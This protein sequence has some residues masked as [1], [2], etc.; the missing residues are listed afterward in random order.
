MMF[1][2]KSGCITYYSVSISVLLLCHDNN[3]THIVHMHTVI[4]HIHSHEKCKKKKRSMHGKLHRHTH[5]QPHMY[6]ISKGIYLPLHTH[7]QTAYGLLLIHLS[8]RRMRVTFGKHTKTII[9][10]MVR[11]SVCVS[12]IKKSDRRVKRY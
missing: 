1:S 9:T 12:G 3:V 4:H 7:K 8:A 10:W 5:T 11:Q 2:V 6:R